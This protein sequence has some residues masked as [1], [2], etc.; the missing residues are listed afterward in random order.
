MTNCSL[1]KYCLYIYIYLS[2]YRIRSLSSTQVLV[3]PSH[4]T[5]DL[6]MRGNQDRFLKYMS[7]VGSKVVM[8]IWYLD[9]E[10]VC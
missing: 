9:S 10:S 6:E 1:E 8:N 7:A 2:L 4:K 3:W 5:L